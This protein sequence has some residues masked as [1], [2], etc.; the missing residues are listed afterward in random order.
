[1]SLERGKFG[2]E[3][4]P[5]QDEKKSS[6]LG[7]VFLAVGLVALVSLS[8]T[9]VRR[10]RDEGS[11]NRE[12]GRS[13][14]ERS[15]VAEAS[16]GGERAQKPEGGKGASA[17]ATPPP[18]PVVQRAAVEKRTPRVRNLLLRLEEAERRRDVDMAVS[19]IEQLRA[20]PGSPAA[21]LDDALARRLGTLNMK[22]LFVAKTPLWVREVTVSRG[23]TAS[24][25]AAENGSTF[26]SFARLNGGSVETIR[27]GQRV[28][29]MDHPRFTLVVHSRARTADLLLKDKFF[30]RYDLA[31]EPTGKT[32][33][34]ELTKGSAA[35]WKSLGVSFKASDQ[36][37]I[38]LLM[39]AGSSVLISE[40]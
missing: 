4:D 5:R 10:H 1:M 22:R 31:K 28:Y 8:V 15:V 39:P 20:L 40:M 33:T 25:I 9:I 38:D 17:V 14:A 18:A 23:D 36:G 24:R 6:G 32:G 30:K 7:W 35:F 12:E 26:A 21:D 19:T 27:I 13:P 11:G 3:W 2:I 34:Y 37:E 16:P 29:V